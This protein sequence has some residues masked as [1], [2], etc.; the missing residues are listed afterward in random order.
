MHTTTVGLRSTTDPLF[1]VE[2]IFARVKYMDD[3]DVDK[4]EA[5]F[6][7]AEDYN[8]AMNM[9]NSMAFI[10]QFGVGQNCGIRCM[11]AN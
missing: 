8:S 10:S 3:I 1:Q 4:L 9:S 7:A 2:K 6:E 11:Y 5:F